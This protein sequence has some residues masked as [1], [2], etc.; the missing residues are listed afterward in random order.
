[1]AVAVAY[2]QLQLG[3]FVFF[4]HLQVEVQVKREGDSRLSERDGER[5]RERGRETYIPYI[6]L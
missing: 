2:L 1:V 3:F 5:W 4:L 6:P